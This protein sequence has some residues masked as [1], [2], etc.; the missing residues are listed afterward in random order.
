MT[1][2][3][4]DIRSALESERSDLLAR[5]D[6]LTVGGDVDLEFDDDFADRGLVASEQGENHTLADA[7]Q[8]QLHMVETAIARVDD[9]TYGSCEVCGVAI[10]DERL[11][12]IPASSRCIDHAE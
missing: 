3:R 9:G 7:L 12:A 1:D 2:T 10:S 4:L 8:A 5:I 6:E 11:N